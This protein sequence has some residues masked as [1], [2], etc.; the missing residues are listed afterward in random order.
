M[1]EARARLARWGRRLREIVSTDELRTFAQR[2][3]E[4]LLL[5]AIT[6]ALTGVGVAL[7]DRAV[8]DGL[9]DRILRLS[10][11]V[12]A[13]AP[14]CG[15]ALA[16]AALRWFG[17]DASPSSADLY[18]QAFHDS[19]KPLRL[20]EVP[21]RML[22]AVATLGFGGAMGLEG[23]SLY[24][25]AS[26][27]TLFHER[28]RRLSRNTDRRALLVAGAAA[29]VAAIFKAPA[30]GAVFA[31]E[32]PYQ[33]DLAHRMLLPALI[34]SATSYL[35]FVAINGTAPILPVRGTPPFSFV[36]LVGAIVLGLLAGFGA[37][38]FSA[39]I[40]FAKHIAT[41]VQPVV[42]IA[43]AGV[44]LALLFAAGYALTG[45]PIV[46][47]VGYATISWALVANRAVWLLLIVLVLR[48]CATAATVAGG[49]V[50][51]LFIP[52][53]VAGALLGRAVG[54]VVGDFDTTLFV[55]IGVAAFL[56][57]GYRVPLAAV[58]FVA[59]TTGRPGFIVPALLAAVAAELVM[60]R[61]SVTT[62][63][64][65]PAPTDSLGEQSDP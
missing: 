12:L 32:V 30:T 42:R 13:V 31:L 17:R 24:L 20:R 7:F 19:R 4:V 5:S 15:L 16:A 6:G 25:G 23:P 51:G 34:G 40:R 48:C 21:G 28:F 8:V 61:W 33:D 50:G 2:S 35:S 56:G 1:N 37:R 10:P 9:L 62:Y 58:T 49:G 47:G 60:G 38:A 29:G 64:Q 36:D 57:A 39:L 59:E 26:I 14:L 55:V 22:A 41:T 44:T 3:R 65:T 18:L 11:W 27:G 46:L 54:G 43:S 52:L 45:R 63:Q 53:V